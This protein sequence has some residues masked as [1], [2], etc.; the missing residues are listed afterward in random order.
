[1]KNIGYLVFLFLVTCQPELITPYLTVNPQIVWQK[2]FGGSGEEMAV[3]I[4]QTNDGGYIVAGYTGSTDGDT[5]G[6]HG[7]YDYYIVKFNKDGTV[8]WQKLLGGS[9]GEVALSIKQTSDGG[10]IVTGRSESTDGDLKNTV[11][12]GLADYWVVKLNENGDI[13][14][15]KCFGGN[16]FDEAYSIIQTS[17]GGYIITGFAYSSDGDLI[18]VNRHSGHDYWIVKLNNVGTI[19]WQKCL[20]GSADDY[21]KIIQQITDGGYIVVGYTFSNDGDMIGNHGNADYCIAKLDEDGTLR[22]IKLLGGK[23]LDEAFSIQQTTDGGYIVAGSSNS[24]DGDMTASHGNNNCWIIKLDNLGNII[25]QKFIGGSGDDTALSVQQTT[26]GGYIIAGY[27]NST[28]GDLKDIA[29]HG[30]YDCWIVKLDSKGNIT[31]QKCLGGSSDDLGTSIQQT[32]DG[33]FIVS[34]CSMST[35]GDLNGIPKNGGYDYWVV[36]LN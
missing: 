5:K 16:G 25:W 27:S 2:C 31:W 14:W 12:H 6:N 18:G 19:S 7:V 10:Y 8:K 11:F 24:T 1:M 36:K 22:W 20:G 3:Y 21:P 33:G 35:D 34:G 26:D 15:Q 23:G 4:Q 29:N 13:V 17:E 9:K 32:T 28:D 30:K